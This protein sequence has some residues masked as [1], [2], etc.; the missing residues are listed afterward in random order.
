MVEEWLAKAVGLVW[1]YP[2]VGL[3]LF[4][5]L[6]FTFRL[7]FIQFRG[8]PH[9]LGLLSGKY[10]HKKEPGELTHFQALTTA[11]SATVG[12]GNIA[13]VAIAIAMGGPGAI[14]WM[15]LVAIFG[16]ATKYVECSLGTMYRKKDPVTGQMKGGAMYYITEGISQSAWPLAVFFSLCLMIG[17]FGA[18]NMFQANQVA[19]AMARTASIPPWVTGIVLSTLVA[20]TIIGG[21]TRI[22][23]VTEKIVPVMCGLYLIG[24]FLVCLANIDQL[25]AAFS[26]IFSDAFSGH[27]AAGGSLGALVIIGVRRA[28]F[29]NESGL[30]SAPI[31]HAS[32]KT[33]YPIREG[34]VA[35]I[36]PFVDTIVVCTATALVII[37]G[38]KYGPELYEMVDNATFT[39]QTPIAMDQSWQKT[40]KAPQAKDQLRPYRDGEVALYYQ[41]GEKGAVLTPPIKLLPEK[42][43]PK[44]RHNR[45]KQNHVT[46]G[47]RFSSLHTES[48]DQ[49]LLVEILDTTGGVIASLPIEKEQTLH[50]EWMQIS[51]GIPGEWSTHLITFTPEFKK[52]VAKANGTLDQVRLRFVANNGSAP[53]YIDRIQ[54]VRKLEGVALT[55]AAFDTYLM[56]HGSLM[57]TICIALFCYSTMI[58]WSHYGETAAHWLFGARGSLPYKVLYVAAA[59]LG[60]VWSLSAVLNFSDLMLGLMVIP[61]TI[62]MFLLFPVVAEKT[63]FYFKK[64]KN[65]EFIVD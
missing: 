56:G 47:I 57:L 43:I 9:A 18:A 40:T 3:C 6:F 41:G 51:A 34:I 24:A 8:F 46:D 64:L 59:Y 33:D 35:S 58:S 31:A 63:R 22:G 52:H 12:L 48:K 42:K 2:V 1:N 50:Q 62:A 10:D 26:V 14:F 25:P 36:G 44:G 15:W 7:G 23:K 13:G 20:I 37:L 53:W 30:G 45:W 11:L 17:S 5:G 60:S 65:G 29:S 38:G 21:I 49:D 55:G 61:N 28:I 19:L 16:M 27:A 39:M 54:S 4:S 32:V